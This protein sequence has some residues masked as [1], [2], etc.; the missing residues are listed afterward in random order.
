[1]TENLVNETL[2]SEYSNLIPNNIK[3]YITKLR[4]FENS[5]FY[6]IIDE[7]AFSSK[8]VCDNN[9]EKQIYYNTMLNDI[10]NSYL[11]VINKYP[12]LLQNFNNI[13]NYLKKKI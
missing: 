11:P 6:D 10:T 1:M 13:I 2:Y 3:F 4:D 7:K 5:D 9:F 8:N 12:I